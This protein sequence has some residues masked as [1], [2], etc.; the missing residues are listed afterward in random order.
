MQAIQRELQEKY[1][2][3]WRPLSPEIG[4]DTLL[5]LMS[6]LGEVADVIKKKGSQKIMEDPE[7]REHFIE[8]LVDVMMYFNDELICYDISIEELKRVYLKKHEK[9][10]KRW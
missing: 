2:D 4:K 5:W 3:K 1:K 6:E 10:M 8:E 7:V 9:N